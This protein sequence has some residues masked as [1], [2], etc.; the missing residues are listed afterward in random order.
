MCKHLSLYLLGILLIM[1]P[2]SAPEEV[3]NHEYL[4]REH[5]LIKPYQGEFYSSI[6]AIT[7]YNY[8]LCPVFH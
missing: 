5:T 7:G 2:L 3:E 1:F 4:K 8:Y 6:T